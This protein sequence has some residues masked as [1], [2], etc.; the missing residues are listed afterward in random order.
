MRGIF[1]FLLTG[2]LQKINH[3]SMSEKYTESSLMVLQFVH[4]CYHSGFPTQRVN[5]SPFTKDFRVEEHINESNTLFFT[6]YSVG[7]N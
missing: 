1:R 4:R 3:A 5:L 7:L 6:P 2:F